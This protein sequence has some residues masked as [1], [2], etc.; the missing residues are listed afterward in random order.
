MILKL[1]DITNNIF[2]RADYDFYFISD[3]EYKKY[4]NRI[5]YSNYDFYINDKKYFVYSLNMNSWGEL[6]YGYNGN[7]SFIKGIDFND[8][9]ILISDKLS[10]G[11]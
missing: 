5:I 11:L 4:D 9:F 10:K 7:F 2:L 8:G 1:S 3:T 6:K